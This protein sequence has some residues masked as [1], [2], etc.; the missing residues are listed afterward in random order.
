MLGFIDAITE[1]S[2]LKSTLKLDKYLDFLAKN[3]YSIAAICDFNMAGYYRF[4]KMAKERNLKPIIGLKAKIESKINRDNYLNLYAYNNQGLT[5]LMKIS[6]IIAVRGY[7][8]DSEIM[9]RNAGLIAV[10]SGVYS[11]LEHMLLIGKIGLFDEELERLKKMTKQFYLG[12]HTESMSF[13]TI[14]LELK[15]YANRYKLNVLP[16]NTSCY[17]EGEEKAYLD[18]LLIGG[19]K[20][21]EAD[22]NLVSKE[23]LKD[24]Y[25]LFS[26]ALSNLDEF[27]SMFSDYELNEERKLPMFKSE[28][29]NNLYI[30]ELCL[31]S[32]NNLERNHKLNDKKENYI[33]RLDYELNIISKMGYIDYILIVAEFISYARKNNIFVGPGRGSACSSL[34]VYLLGIT[35]ID[36]LKYD[37]YFE[38]FLNPER[39]SM[40]DI[41]VDF[42]DERKDEVIKH[43]GALYGKNHV[44]YITTYQTFKE[45]NTV[46]DLFRI[47]NIDEKQYQRVIEAI[48]NKLDYH[49]IFEDHPEL[50]EVI[51]EVK[52]LSDLKRAY[53]V[54]PSGI[55]LTNEDIYSKLP[56]K[57]GNN[58]LY[59]AQLTQDD[60]EKM[61]YLKFDFLSLSYV[62][63]LREL[64]ESINKR[65]NFNLDEI[66]LEDKDT[67]S[68]LQRGETLGIFQIE[69]RNFTKF[70]VDMKI[71]CFNDLIALLA[72]YR[73][74]PLNM[75]PV[76][77]KRKEGEQFSYLDSRLED[78][79]KETYGIIVYQEQVMKILQVVAGFSLGEADLFRRAIA[80]KNKDIIERNHD[81]Y[82]KRA[83]DRGY[84]KEVAEEIFAKIEEFSNYG[85]NKTHSVAYALFVYQLAYIKTHYNRDFIVC[86]LNRNLQNKSGL[87]IYYDLARKYNISFIIPDINKSNNKFEVVNDQVLIPLQAINGV[88]N[89]ISSEIISNRGKGYVSFKDF[90]AKNTLE[91]G[92]I[93]AMIDAFVFDSFG[94][95]HKDMHNIVSNIEFGLI[96]D[97]ERLEI[98]DE[99]S[100]G[101]LKTREY[102][103][104]NYNFKFNIFEKYE[105]L[106]QE[107]KASGLKD[108]KKEGQPVNVIGVISSIKVIK[109]KDNNDMAIINLNSKM[110]FIE[111]VLFSDT[112]QTY[113]DLL[114]NKK[115]MLFNGNVHI[116]KGRVNVIVQK[117]KSLE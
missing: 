11:D 84:S 5:N 85:F 114:T 55:I 86:S 81:D 36:P 16:L 52:I 31:N 20:Q 40:P 27:V 78:I 41:D 7:V 101:E 3:D 115:M 74:G 62:T 104:L 47:K 24:R 42:E 90:L 116:Y 50:I 65:T 59:Q 87:K 23:E 30:K 34:V 57:N 96:N 105:K 6:S 29:N 12:I 17:F 32:L 106:K 22:F 51:E 95:T 4:I 92:V 9:E 102:N 66:N 94:Q 33:A 39:V 70:V 80:K 14:Y 88:T 97:E 76:Y 98:K 1:Y 45:K 25:Q 2:L 63:F 72:L 93:N 73:P 75:I 117:L 8:L 21:I 111:L 19:Y 77:I 100:L 53:S 46:R 13:D 99:Y 35:K 10:T 58:E 108:L 82:L 37:L 44:C 110:E 109:T 91:S 64:V 48:E 112:Y 61:G 71:S 67:Y 107:Y 18:L 54:H 38:R 49:E 43:L 103:A 79:L 15:E 56:L 113:K 60:L 68:L 26:D 89:N 69:D 28:K 83:L